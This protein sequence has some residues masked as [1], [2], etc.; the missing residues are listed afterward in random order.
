MSGPPPVEGEPVLLLHGFMGRGADWTDVARSIGS[1]RKVLFPDLPGHGRATNLT[2]SD[3]TMDGAADRLATLLSREGISRASVIGYSMGGRL[4]LH[5]ALRQP[6]FVAR[7][8]LISASPGLATEAERIE[9]Q[10]LD[11][12]R[13]RAIMGDLELFLE[14]W[15]KMP[16]FESLDEQTRSRLMASRAGNVP[17]ELQKSLYGMGTGSQPSHWEHLHSIRVPAWAIVGANDPK[18]VSIAERMTEAGQIESIVMP[19]VGHAILAEQPE[20]LAS[21]IRNIIS[22]T[23]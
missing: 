11:A 21:T 7:L 23:R 13:G 16:P 19:G 20:R 22:P 10:V 2:A 6:E 15:Y 8:V 12:E 9:R 4:A 1:D 5:F 18:F 3:Y 17:S 14:S